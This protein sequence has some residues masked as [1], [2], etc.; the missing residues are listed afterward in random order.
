MT[1][2]SILALFPFSL[3]PSSVFLIIVVVFIVLVV[4]V[5]VPVINSFLALFLL[6]IPLFCTILFE[7]IL[8]A[9]LLLLLFFISYLSI[10]ISFFWSF[11]SEISFKSS[12]TNGISSFPYS[13]ISSLVVYLLTGFET[14]LYPILFFS[15][16]IPIFFST[17]LVTIF[18][19]SFL[20]FKVS[21]SLPII[22]LV[23]I[24][25]IGVLLLSS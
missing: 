10:I 13:I 22:F 18:W 11:P 5:V 9:F 19:P 16:G 17:I 2:F 4:V 12:L 14:S 6:F 1:F 7:Y 23:I 15:N 25:F 21:I 8:F 3:S 20:L 24:V